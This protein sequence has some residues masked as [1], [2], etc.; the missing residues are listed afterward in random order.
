MA[1]VV[2][3]IV[4]FLLI[5]LALGFM[6]GWMMRGWGLDG[7]TRMSDGY[8]QSQREALL[9]E[10]NTARSERDEARTQMLSMRANVADTEGKVAQRPA[11]SAAAAAASTSATGQTA[12]SDLPG[13]APGTA[14]VAA[15]ADASGADDLKRI[16]GV[17]PR[18]EQTLHELGITRFAQ[19]AAWTDDDVRKVNAKLR[20]QGRIERDGWIAQARSFIDE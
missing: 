16:K 6:A 17:G 2:L 19:I 13:A 15:P 1:Y 14:R 20:F 5:A 11:P 4:V 10:L 3:Q 12:K 18:L 8:E 9:R 7:S